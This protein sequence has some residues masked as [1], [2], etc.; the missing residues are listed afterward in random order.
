MCVVLEEGGELGGG[1]LG[2]GP[3]PGQ[4]EGEAGHGDGG[5]GGQAHLAPILV[6]VVQERLGVRREVLQLL[7]LLGTNTRLD[8]TSNNSK[9]GL[10]IVPLVVGPVEVV[11]VLVLEDLLGLSSEEPLGLG[12][13]APGGLGVLHGGGGE[14]K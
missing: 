10:G 9:V 13:L 12:V 2:D 1:G 5:V 3:G 4:V 8:I 14:R 6:V 7:V 11:E